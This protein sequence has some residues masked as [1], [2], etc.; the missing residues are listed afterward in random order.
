MKPSIDDE[1]WQKA[2][3]IVISGATI[4]LPFGVE[5]GPVAVTFGNRFDLAERIAAAIRGAA[6]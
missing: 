6:A 2:K 4:L 5:S 3:A 1:A